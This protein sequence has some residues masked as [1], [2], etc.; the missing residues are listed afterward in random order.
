MIDPSRPSQYSFQDIFEALASARSFEDVLDVILVT[1]LRELQADQGSLLLLEGDEENPELKMLAARGLP[2]EIVR[3]GYIPRK[4]SISEYV[5]RERRP[6]ILN[7]APRTQK[8]ETMSAE[9]STPRKIVSAMCVPLIARG[10]VLGTMN[11]NRTRTDRAIFTQNDL[12]AASIIAGQAA[13]TIEN[14]RL[15]EELLQKERLAAVGQTVAGISHCIKNILAG[16]KGGLGITQMGLDQ[17]NDDLVEQGY[18]LLK[19]NV[20]TLGNLVLDLLDYSKEREPM[21]DTFDLAR[22]IQEVLSTLA[23]K[24]QS[25]RVNLLSD[26]EGPTHFHGDSDQIFRALLNL[27]TNAIEAC[28][29]FS[30]NGLPPEVT[31]RLGPVPTA[32]L[33]AT[34]IAKATQWLRLEVQDNGPG[35][36]AELQTKIWDLFFST[37]GSRGTGI[38]LA[39]TRKMIDEHG[40]KIELRSSPD[41]GTCFT[42]MLPNLPSQ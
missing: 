36:P 26:I 15:Q 11:L 38:G 34:R 20:G 18:D 3:R 4:G 16:V 39:A 17:K 35:I 13:I 14:R 8:Y 33:S 2:S 19:R 25:G 40:G 41:T 10:A 37:K 9:T 1:A 31:I 22:T 12:E 5:L 23:F 42:I 29:D 6:L 24:A 21:R 7:E 32:D 30:R 27:A 28:A